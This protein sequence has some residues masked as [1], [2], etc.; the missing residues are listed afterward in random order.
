MDAKSTPPNTKRIIDKSRSRLPYVRRGDGNKDIGDD[1][2]D[3]NKGG[4]GN[5]IVG[6]F[7][8]QVLPV[9]PRITQG[10]QSVSGQGT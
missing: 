7:T 10:L 3:A 5:A 9:A 2:D 1:D 6:R 8:R 4:T